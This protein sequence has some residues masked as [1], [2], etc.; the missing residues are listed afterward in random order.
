MC[1]VISYNMRSNTLTNKDTL[2][3]VQKN[4]N[5]QQPFEFIY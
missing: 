1:V 3:T 2:I 4:H 5:M